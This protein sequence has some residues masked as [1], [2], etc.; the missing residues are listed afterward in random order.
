MLREHLQENNP[1]SAIGARGIAGYS[2]TRPLRQ[3]VWVGHLDLFRSCRR[4]PWTI[5]R[6]YAWPNPQLVPFSATSEISQHSTRTTLTSRCSVGRRICRE[7]KAVSSAIEDARTRFA[8]A[9][10]LTRAWRSITSTNRTRAK[11]DKR[12]G[13]EGLIFLAVH[14]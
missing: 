9:T 8:R 12:S 4:I 10:R 1:P 3:P 14:V 13:R 7:E 6:V 11:D 5:K 2:V